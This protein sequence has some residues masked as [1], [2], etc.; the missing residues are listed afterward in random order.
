MTDKK[1]PNYTKF[2][3][4]PAPLDALAPPARKI[5]APIEKPEIP[6]AEI[7]PLSD[8][9]ASEEIK[10]GTAYFERI[11]KTRE[12]SSKSVRSVAGPAHRAFMP[13]KRNETESATPKPP[14]QIRAITREVHAPEPDPPRTPVVRDP[15]LTGP[16]PVPVLLFAIV[17]CLAACFV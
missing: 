15:L 10:A 14:K 7:I 13:S 5:A 11:P 4:K 6:W 8:E 3:K 16:P 2:M 12:K 9:E 1:K 17:V